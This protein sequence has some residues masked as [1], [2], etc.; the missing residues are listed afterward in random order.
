M[1]IT[2][3]ANPR[4]TD[5]SLV[6]AEPSDISAC[7]GILRL[8]HVELVLAIADRHLVR[9]ATRVSLASLASALDDLGVD[10]DC[11]PDFVLD[12]KAF[13]VQQSQDVSAVARFAPAYAE[14]P[15]TALRALALAFVKSSVAVVSD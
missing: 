8:L 3:S 2:I 5:G 10:V 13:I 4:R 1:S 14:D 11:R 9:S 6:P 7:R 15:C 12:L